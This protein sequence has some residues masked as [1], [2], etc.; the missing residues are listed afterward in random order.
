MPTT[1]ERRGDF[2]FGFEKDPATHIAM[3]EIPEEPIESRRSRSSSSRD[4]IQYRP[5]T[6]ETWLQS[7]SETEFE[8]SQ[9]T[10]YVLDER[11]SRSPGSTVDIDIEAA[12]T[13]GLSLPRHRE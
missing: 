9:H 11:R 13:R 12:P 1:V 3:K 6:A 5:Q 4:S 2:A 10:R 8:R 7:D